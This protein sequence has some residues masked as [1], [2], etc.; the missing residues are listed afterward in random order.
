MESFPSQLGKVMLH[1]K[2]RGELD[3]NFDKTNR[4]IIG[5]MFEQLSGQV[6]SLAV[7]IA[8]GSE[9]QGYIDQLMDEMT[10]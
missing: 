2:V 9:V 1:L 4:D 10:K 3:S 6:E 8:N 7:Q 5:H